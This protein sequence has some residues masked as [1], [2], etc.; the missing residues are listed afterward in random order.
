MDGVTYN[1]IIWYK[2][3][4]LIKNLWSEFI[5]KWLIISYFW[6]S[7]HHIE[8][9]LVHLTVINSI[10]FTL[11][12]AFTHLILLFI[13]KLEFLC[14]FRGCCHSSFLSF[15]VLAILCLLEHF[16]Y[17]LVGFI[18]FSERVWSAFSSCSII[19]FWIVGEAIYFIIVLNI[20]HIGEFTSL[21]SP[22]FCF[23]HY[24]ACTIILKIYSSST[25][26]RRSLQYLGPLLLSLKRTHIWWNPP[27]WSIRLISTAHEGSTSIN[28][29]ETSVRLVV[30]HKWAI[31]R[32][33]SVKACIRLVITHWFA[34]HAYVLE[35]SIIGG[36]TLHVEIITLLHFSFVT[37]CRLFSLV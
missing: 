18:I 17:T 6:L 9:T 26:A 3:V 31:G 20:H 4:P 34:S 32:V 33:C 11:H 16:I 2:I 21:S 12:I 1:C 19:I 7:L 25:C 23:L 5:L 22:V 28:S 35:L 10:N 30:T 14:S 13:R 15:K 24:C 8:I 36:L 27:E 29:V 37:S